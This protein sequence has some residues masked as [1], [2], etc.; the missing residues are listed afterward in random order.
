MILAPTTEVFIKKQ[1]A[2]S[3]ALTPSPLE[4]PTYYTSTVRYMSNL[5]VEVH[6]DN[7]VPSCGVIPRPSGLLPC[8]YCPNM[9]SG[10]V[11]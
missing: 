6:K 1:T 8:Y 11:A 10:S 4:T 2:L 7:K 5:Q 3:A 9:A